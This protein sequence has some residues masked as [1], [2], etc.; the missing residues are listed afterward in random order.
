MKSIRRR[1]VVWLLGGLALLWIVAGVGVY[2]SVRQG[3]IKSIDAELA[4]DALTVRF[5][6][7]GD[8]DAESR[9]RGPKLKDRLTAYQVENG[10]SFY[11]IWPPEGGVVERSDSLGGLELTNPGAVGKEDVFTNTRMS[12]GR[13]VRS[14]V[15]RVPMNAGRGP[16]KGKG[17]F[18]P[19][20]SVVMLAKDLAGV[21]RTLSALLGGLFIVG[22]LAGLGAVALVGLALRDGLGPLDRLREA[23]RGIDASS[24]SSRFPKDGVPEE[25]L[26]VYGS[27]NELLSRL[28]RGFDRERRFSADLAHEM[29]TPVAELKMLSEVALKWP[30]ESGPNTHGQTLEIAQRLQATIDSLLNLARWESGDSQLCVDSVMIGELVAECWE[31]WAAKAGERELQTN[32]QIREVVV[33][34][35]DGGVLRVIVNN[36]L[37]NAVEYT[38]RG[39]RVWVGVETDLIRVANDAPDL[40]ETDL[41]RMFERFWRADASRSGTG[42]SGLG[43]SLARQGAEMLGLTLD[44][45]LTDGVLHFSLKKG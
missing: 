18:N 32:F 11:Q 40:K 2:R 21:E 35:T 36:L 7:R 30:E 8:E 1:L 15:F 26:P 38:P 3:L 14:M 23:T 28:E 9:A 37:S 25:L 31:P 19:A 41:E 17:R 34:E 16:G 45:N 10:D 12:D 39:G 6:G 33:W 42:H 27:L 13:E 20:Y 29:R 22:L 5:V 24:L 4:A 43:L 44:A